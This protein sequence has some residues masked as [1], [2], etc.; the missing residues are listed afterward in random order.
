MMSWQICPKCFGE[1]QTSNGVYLVTCIL[2]N[3][4]GIINMKTGLPPSFSSPLEKV[5]TEK[6]IHNLDNRETTPLDNSG[7]SAHS[8]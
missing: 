4:W 3:G 8:A 5:N 7:D 6:E 1:K 2:C